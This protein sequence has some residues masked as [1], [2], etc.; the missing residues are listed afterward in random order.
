MAKAGNRARASSPDRMQGMQGR[1]HGATRES[2]PSRS[3]PKG[4][5]ARDSD[6]KSKIAE[7]KKTSALASDKARKAAAQG[8]KAQAA[9]DLRGAAQAARRSKMDEE[10]AE[11][12][13]RKAL[14]AARQ[15]AELAARAAKK[16]EEAARNSEDVLAKKR[17]EEE[18]NLAELKKK[19]VQQQGKL[20]ELKAKAAKASSKRVAG[21]DDVVISAPKGLPPP[22]EKFSLPDVVPKKPR[23]SSE[24]PA[25][26]GL[27]PSPP[28]PR[29]SDGGSG[30]SRPTT[31]PMRT[32]APSGSRLPTPDRRRSSTGGGPTAPGSV[33]AP[34]PLRGPSPPPL[35]A[36]RRPTPPATSIAS[37]APRRKSPSGGMA[38]AD[39]TGGFTAAG[40]SSTP[41]AGLGNTLDKWPVSYGVLGGRV[42]D[43]PSGYYGG[44]PSAAGYSRP[45]SRGRGARPG[46]RAGVGEG[47]VATARP[48]SRG[49]VAT[50]APSTPGGY[51]F[52]PGAPSWSYGAPLPDGVAGLHLNLGESQMTAIT[53]TTS[54]RTSEPTRARRGVSCAQ[55]IAE[56]VQI[57]PGTAAVQTR[58]SIAA[59][60]SIAA[61][62]ASPLAQP[63]LSSLAHTTPSKL[64]TT[65]KIPSPGGAAM[66]ARA[67]HG[68]AGA[69]QPP[70]TRGSR[71]PG[72]HPASI[73]ASFASLGG[74]GAHSHPRHGT[75]SRIPARSGDAPAAV[76]ALPTSRFQDYP[77]ESSASADDR[78]LAARDG[79]NAG[80]GE[81][82][83]TTTSA[84]TAAGAAAE[85]AAPHANA[86]PASPTTPAPLPMCLPS[87]AP[88]VPPADKGS[89]LRMLA[90]QRRSSQALPKWGAREPSPSRAA[91]SAGNAPLEGPAPGGRTPRGP[92]SSSSGKGP[93]AAS[94]PEKEL[95]KAAAKAAAAGRAAARKQKQQQQQEKLRQQAEAG[96]KP[97]Q[98]V[99]A[100]VKET[101][102]NKLRASQ[103]SRASAAGP[104]AL[105]VASAEE[106]SVPV[107]DATA[108]VN[109]RHSPRGSRS[110]SPGRSRSCGE[111]R[112]GSSADEGE[113]ED[114]L[115][116]SSVLFPGSPGLRHGALSRDVY[117]QRR[118]GAP[119]GHHHAAAAPHA[120]ATGFRA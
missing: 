5:M 4:A 89:A 65:S 66:G 54:S 77:P 24:E 118:A 39:T 40:A 10:E 104:R 112:E 46:S 38:S 21:S 106:P 13:R 97:R 115:N 99:M 90:A 45:E 108:R 114:E 80:D 44:V 64:P 15:E 100:P 101:A 105:G 53:A 81:S 61:A 3:E 86:G 20:A 29:P 30:A 33:H 17:M 120:V 63:R 111:R 116:A 102:M 25:T 59:L 74:P 12:E 36:R 41:S 1:T 9:A 23:V 26:E 84:A 67:P 103:A 58:A 14:G 7:A 56:A 62:H 52:P 93:D 68:A 60:A 92:A 88:T 2:T 34:S 96:D 82:V 91:P 76:A 73:S 35:P 117:A 55:G 109:V 94:A 43:E 113:Y 19:H 42:V 78:S 57:A 70:Q 107:G 16:E 50:G 98:K 32:S 49:S 119:D 6:L 28:P 72:G 87:P 71:L 48:V 85:G 95:G 31:R 47:H 37:L 110:P 75:P 79:E 8:E 22:V 83:A 18:K 27:A 51:G 11:A 69:E